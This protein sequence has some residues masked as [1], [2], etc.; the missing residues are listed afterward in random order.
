MAKRYIIITIEN[1]RV[2]YEVAN[3][4]HMEIQLALT[5]VMRDN[6]R[7]WQ[8]EQQARSRRSEE[9]ADDTD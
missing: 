8:E 2:E 5:D 1:G 9:I 4:P 6:L 7:K 3:L